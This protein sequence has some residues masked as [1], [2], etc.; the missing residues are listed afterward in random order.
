MDIVTSTTNYTEYV[1]NVAVVGTCLMHHVDRIREELEISNVNYK[2]LIKAFL[3]FILKLTALEINS[4]MCYFFLF[5][6]NRMKNDDKIRILK[7]H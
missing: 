5:T 7:I 6:K 1:K 3:Q 4:D 2:S